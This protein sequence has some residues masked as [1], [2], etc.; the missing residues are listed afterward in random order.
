MTGLRADLALIAAS[1]AKGSRVLDIGCGDGTLLQY[2]ERQCGVDGRGMELSTQGVH[3]SI[4]KGLAVIQGD[5]DTDLQD[6]SPNAFDYVVLSQTLQATHNPREVVQRIVRIGRYGIIS[7]PNFG[8]WRIRLSLLW[9][10]RMPITK[11]LPSQWYETPN[12]H[13]CSVRDFQAMCRHHDIV[14]EKRLVPHANWLTSLWAN[15]FA[16]EVIFIISAR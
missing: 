7:F 1:I 8:Y 4:K 13:L 2:L 9:F 5:A 3:D 14:I 12:I 10:G 11:T 16:Q 6:Y 15:L